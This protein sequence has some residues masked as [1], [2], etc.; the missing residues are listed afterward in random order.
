MIKQ[1]EYFVPA[2]VDKSILLRRIYIQHR[3]FIHEAM[4]DDSHVYDVGSFFLS[5]S[6][7]LK[8]D[9]IAYHCEIE[10]FQVC[11]NVLA[12]RKWF[13]FYFTCVV[14]LLLFFSFH[15]SLQCEPIYLNFAERAHVPPFVR[16]RYILHSCF[17]KFDLEYI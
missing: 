7:L 17:F 14:L 1:S 5:L 8:H 13:Y 16:I 12:M 11:V 9:C 15:L 4:V 10:I 3:Y 6:F 2:K